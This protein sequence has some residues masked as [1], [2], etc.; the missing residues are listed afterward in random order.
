MRYKTIGIALGFLVLIL[1]GCQTSPN[2]TAIPPTLEPTRIATEAPVYGEDHPDAIPGRYIV[3]FKKGANAVPIL[4]RLQSGDVSTLGVSPSGVTV[5][6]VYTAA[7]SGFA[8]TLSAEALEALKKNPDVAYIE[9]DRVV[10]LTATQTSAPWGLDR[11][12]QRDLPLD[13][14]YTYTYTGSGVHVYV[15]DTGIR[16]THAEFTGR[17]G[18]GYTAINDGNGYADCNGHGTHVAGTIGG[19]TYG[20]A[21]GV[22]LH[23]VRVLDCSGSGTNSGVIAGV[24]WVTQNHQSPAVANMSLG[25]GASQALDDAVRNSI[26]AGVTYVVAAGNENTDACTKSPA[27]VSE[28]ITVAATDST[29]TRAS[30]SNYGSCVDLFAPGVNITS[31]WHTS[32]TATNT[33]SGTSMATPHVAGVAALYLEQNPTATPAQVKDAILSGATAGRVSGTNGSPNLLLY[34]LIDGSGGSGAPCTNCEYY[35]GYL[36]GAGDYAYQPNGT[37]YY[38]ST[39]G[40][41]NGWL[42]GASGTDFDLYLWKWNGYQWVTVASSTSYTSSESISYYGSPGYYVWRIYAYSGAGSYEFWMERP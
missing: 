8:A 9:A 31:A 30:F 3:V 26:A 37:Y 11:I 19:S 12:D 25:G 35:T 32:D 13:N 27:R 40:Y 7:L 24:D 33:I 42:E 10:R 21:K 14:S 41:H 29:D 38:A 6:R 20:V 2:A 36:S 28:A 34:S 22:T 23:P 39:Y 1:A 16:T 5:H 4:Q 17:I 18:N 15:I